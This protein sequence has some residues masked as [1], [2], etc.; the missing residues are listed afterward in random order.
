VEHRN[1]LVAVITGLAVLGTA[2][3]APAPE[4]FRLQ[5]TLTRDPRTALSPQLIVEEGRQGVIELTS[6]EGE[7]I[8]LRATAKRAEHPQRRPGKWVQVSMQLFEQGDQGW[9][10]RAEPG[11]LVPLA[12]PGA[13]G[14]APQASSAFSITSDSTG[15]TLELTLLANLS[16]RTSKLGGQCVKSLPEPGVLAQQAPI[17]PDES[18]KCC[19]NC[20]SG[21]RVCCTN[22]CCSNGSCGCCSNL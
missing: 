5:F 13:P 12:E 7:G 6:D 14:A 2:A 19:V 9:V 1:W 22:S 21:W 11:M 3:A 18:T 20:G 17:T 8:Q 10:L 16:D 15:S 4:T